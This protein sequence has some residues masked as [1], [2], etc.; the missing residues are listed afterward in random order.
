MGSPIQQDSLRQIIG[1]YYL[2]LKERW[3]TKIV[4]RYLVKVGDLIRDKDDGIV[5][6]I[7]SDPYK[8]GL[9]EKPGNDAIDVWWTHTARR[10]PMHL[11]AFEHNIELIP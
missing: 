2:A 1:M 7:L 11:R 6:I 9:S 5:G 3:F 10:V 4:A 8:W